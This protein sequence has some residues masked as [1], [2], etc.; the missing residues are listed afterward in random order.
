MQML[1]VDPFLE[2]QLNLL[3]NFQR[4]ASPKKCHT[5]F[6]VTLQISILPVSY[7]KS[8][9]ETWPSQVEHLFLWHTLK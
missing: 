4:T 5:N 8:Q 2:A 6:Q 7:V 3:A 9:W 1:K